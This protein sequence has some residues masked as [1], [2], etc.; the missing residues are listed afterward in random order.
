MKE[1]P[2][3][4]STPM[5]QAVLD[6]KKTMTRRI[7]KGVPDMGERWTVS[8]PYHTSEFWTFSGNTEAKIKCQYGNVGDELW[9][10]ETWAPYPFGDPGR[11][12]TYIAYKADN[13]VMHCHL[14]PGFHKSYT[15]GDASRILKWKP[16]I[17]M[18]RHASRINLKITSIR[19]EQIQDIKESDCIAE[20]IQSD[21]HD[22]KLV[23]KNYD[24]TIGGETWGNAL[25]SF[26]SLWASINGQESW[27]RNPFV[28]VIEFEKLY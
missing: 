12:A 4:L 10:R 19:V 28:W 27:F 26:Q 23:Y 8:N 2:I 25:Y 22:G 13:S 5:V 24:K 7:I 9:V 6:N 20:G 21:E 18:H 3:I 11:S 15:S 16:S 17:H 1:R 14:T